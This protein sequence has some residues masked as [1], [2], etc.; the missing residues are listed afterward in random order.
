MIHGPGYVQRSNHAATDGI[1]RWYAV[2]TQPQ[3]ETMAETHLQRLSVQVWC[4]R[5][6]QRVILHGYRREVTRPL[7]PG[8]LFAAFDFGRAFRAVHHAHGVRGVVTFGN[9]PAEVAAALLASIEARM[10][11]GYVVVEPTPLR[12]G[13]RVE[14][15]AGAFQGFTGLFQSRMSGAERVTILLDTLRY[16]ARM[17]IDRAAVRPV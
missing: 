10:K 5:Y 17:T 11:D 4:P 3:R 14:I 2:E 9:E 1:P 16:N 6:R 15:I 12:E 8:Y 13:Q 7:F